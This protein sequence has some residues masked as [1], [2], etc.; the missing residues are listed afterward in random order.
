MAKQ[1]KDAKPEEEEV[2]VAEVSEEEAEALK[3]AKEK[4]ALQMEEWK[5]RMTDR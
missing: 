5:Y 3:A 2:V 1:K 4:A